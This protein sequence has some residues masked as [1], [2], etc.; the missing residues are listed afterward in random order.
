M[1]WWLVDSAVVHDSVSVVR[2]T[3]HFS[4]QNNLGLMIK[5]YFTTISQ[6][7]TPGYTNSNT[8]LHW[9]ME[10]RKLSGCSSD[11]SQ[12]CWQLTKYFKGIKGTPLGEGYNFSWKH[13]IWSFLLI[14]LE[15]Q[16]AIT[17]QSHYNFKNG[18][19]AVILPC[20]HLGGG[21]QHQQLITHW[22]QSNASCLVNSA[23][24][25]WRHPAWHLHTLPVSLYKLPLWNQEKINLI[26]KEP[27]PWHTCLTPSFHLEIWNSKGGPGGGWAT[28]VSGHKW[29]HV[30]FKNV[31]H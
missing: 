22:E 28:P 17:V 24:T 26:Y 20:K 15:P 19:K 14:V 23:N 18:Y 16:E 10:E 1:L 5:V 4:P 25:P 31:I 6:P 9:T 30:Q 8:L 21:G 27:D 2:I 12:V 7:P 11:P 29:H 13:F 3:R